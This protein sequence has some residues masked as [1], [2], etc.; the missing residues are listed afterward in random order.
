MTLSANI[1]AKRVNRN[2]TQEELAA[3]LGVSNQAVSK[4]ERG[5]SYPDIT[6]LPRMALYFETTLDELCG[7]EEYRGEE[8]KRRLIEELGKLHSRDGAE[9][10]IPEWRKLYAEYP[11]DGYIAGQFANLLFSTNDK[12]TNAAAEEA[13]G[14][15]LQYISS[16]PEEPDRGN[17]VAALSR[18]YEIMGAAER[19]YAFALKQ[20]AFFASRDFLIQ[21]FLRGDDLKRARQGLMYT[22]IRSEFLT[23][24]REY[25]STP[26]DSIYFAKKALQ[27]IDWIFDD[28]APE[29]EQ[30]YADTMRG[31]WYSV[32]AE[33]YCALRDAD[34][35]MLWLGKLA[36]A[37]VRAAGHS[38]NSLFK[39]ENYTF[40]AKLLEHY[41][42]SSISGNMAESV[43]EDINSGKFDMLKERE[44]FIALSK[45]LQELRT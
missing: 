15:L 20:P 39:L 11:S 45:A 3:A 2:V 14:V 9:A 23:Y 30:A 29:T 33:S 40:K 7:M 32:C 13:V 24:L 10:L 26:E 36:E 21:Q 4:W 27:L 31:E 35:A 34:N 8:R 44:G 38:Q 41:A 28:T 17:A 16:H 6:L 25:A 42:E 43:I 22:I 18:M 37:A 12:T 5:E 1:R 19:G